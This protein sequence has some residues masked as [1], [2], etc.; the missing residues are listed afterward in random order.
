MSIIIIIDYGADILK[1]DID[2]IIII[3]TIKCLITRSIKYK[4]VY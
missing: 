4:S 1:P 2:H 3:I